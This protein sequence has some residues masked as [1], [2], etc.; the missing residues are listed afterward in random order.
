MTFPK[1]YGRGIGRENVVL[2]EGEP[3]GKKKVFT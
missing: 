3:D 2:T 1:I